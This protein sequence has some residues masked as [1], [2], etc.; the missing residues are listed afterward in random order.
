[1]AVLD[2]ESID[3]ILRELRPERSE[4]LELLRS[5]GPEGWEHATECPLYSV[6]GVA[7]HI[8]GDDLSLLSRQRDAAENGLIQLAGELPGGD[9]RSLLD[10]FNDRWVSAARF[11]STELAVELLGLTGEWTAAYYE[12]VDPTAA[13]EPVGFFGAT[14]PHSP[15][16]QAIAREYVE[17]WVHHS[18]IRRALG[19]GSLSDHRFLA[20][21][22]AVA[23]AAAGVE[24]GVPA[25]EGDPWTIGPVE[26]GSPQQAADILTRAHTADA[27]RQIA[28]GPTEAVDLLAFFAGRP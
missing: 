17:R 19:L 3:L 11:L 8:L 27:I 20:A 4:L 18:Q 6:K 21:G 7:T 10:T 13:G 22:V 15:F 14:G 1:M 2:A 24:A 28:S 12:A 9:F 25:A 23:A 26:L 16:W 5:L